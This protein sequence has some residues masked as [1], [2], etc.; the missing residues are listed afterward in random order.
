MGES[1]RDFIRQASKIV[2]E[3]N[4][5]VKIFSLPQAIENSRQFLHLRT[6]ISEKTVVAGVPMNKYKLA[7]PKPH[8][9]F[10]KRNLS[11]SGN[12]LWNSLTLEVRQLTSLYAFKGKFKKTLI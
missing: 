12:V 11:R 8:T 3:W 4:C 2:H 7:V 6:D 10:Y 5:H 1:H 9:E